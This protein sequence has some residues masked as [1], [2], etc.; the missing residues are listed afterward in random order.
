M[1]YFIEQLEAWRREARLM[2]AESLIGMLLDETGYAAYCAAM[3]GG[4]QRQ[5]NLEALCERAIRQGEKNVLRMSCND[6]VVRLLPG[7]LNF[8][9][10]HPNYQTEQIRACEQ[11][12]RF[13]A[14]QDKE[15]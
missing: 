12:I 3:P 15:P 13:D 10:N 4:R 11:E 8:L 9:Q 5:A 14:V 7:L 6:T 2:S 1:R